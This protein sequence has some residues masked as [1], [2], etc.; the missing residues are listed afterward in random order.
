MTSPAKWFAFSFL[1]I[2][3]VLGISYASSVQNIATRTS[4]EI[5]V[6]SDIEKVGVI[7]NELDENNQIEYVDV[8]EL[9]A[10]FLIEVASVQ[11]NLNYDIKV[12]FVYLD[13]NGNVTKNEKDI[14]G[15][16]YRLQYLNDKG[17]VKGTA[18]GR[19]SLH[20]LSF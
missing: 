9:F 14:R 1:A 19:Q 7:R 20:E 18:E 16:Q 15:I 2:F 17:E 12:E 8:E 11:K 13:K 6:L 4:S 10:R 5:D 3:I